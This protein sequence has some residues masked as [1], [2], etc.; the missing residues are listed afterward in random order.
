MA[1]AIVIGIMPTIISV[2]EK[3]KLFDRVDLHRKDHK[4]LISRLGGVAIFV[5]FTITVLFFAPWIHYESANFLI[6]GCFIIGAMGLKDDVSGAS[7]MAKLF[8]QIGVAVLLVFFGH[9]SLTSL[10][11]VFGIGDIN[12][13]WGSLFSVLLIIFLSNIFNLIDGIDGLATSIGLLVSGCFGI[14]FALMHQSPYALISFALFGALLA[15]LKFNWCPA[16]IFMGD[17][18]SLVIGLITS[19]LAIRF[20]ELN[21]VNALAASMY[22]SAP[23]IAVSIL[24]VPIFDSLRMFTVR[25]LKRKSPF[26]GDRNHTHHRL[27]QLGLK[28]NKIVLILVVF[29]AL[30]VSLVFLL[31]NLGNFVLICL[32]IVACA[33]FNFGVTIALKRK[34][35][36]QGL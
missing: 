20:V 2:S 5:S 30:F 11:G 15:F 31:Q 32:M 35:N 8:L 14:L 17:T 27:E 24:I 21:K 10:Y 33:L 36:V 34:D 16:K 22:Y 7:L 29:N 9:Y 28:P 23:A 3:Y 1:L 13:I 26:H 25:I 6:I 18:G 19:V 12:Y 4:G